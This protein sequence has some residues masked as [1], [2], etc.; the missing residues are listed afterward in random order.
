MARNPYELRWELYQQAENRL[1]D[2][3]R[4]QETRYQTLI[5]KGEDPG[6]YPEYPSDEAIHSLA[7]SMN[8]FISGEE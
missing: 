7:K 6:E 5:E 8:A 2:R 3:Y 1:V 4:A